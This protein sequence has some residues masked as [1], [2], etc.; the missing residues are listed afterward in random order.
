MQEYAY[1]QD[2]KRA[3]KQLNKSPTQTQMDDLRTGQAELQ[4]ETDSELSTLDQQEKL[5][6]SYFQSIIDSATP[7]GTLSAISAV[8]SHRSPQPAS[9]GAI[10]VSGA[11]NPTFVNS[12][13][14]FN[15]NVRGKSSVLH[16]KGRKGSP[17]K[18]LRERKTGKPEL[19]AW[20]IS[21]LCERISDEWQKLASILGFSELE[22]TAFQHENQ[23]NV[24][25]CSSVLDT[26]LKRQGNNEEVRQI[27]SK[28]ITNIGRGDVAGGLFERPLLR[29]KISMTWKTKMDDASAKVSKVAK[30][31]RFPFSQMDVEEKIGKI[32]QESQAN[33]YKVETGQMTFTICVES[34]D[35]LESLWHKYTTGELAKKLSETFITDEVTQEVTISESDYKQACIFFKDLESTKYEGNGQDASRKAMQPEQFGKDDFVKTTASANP[36]RQAAG[37]SDEATKASHMTADGE[38]GKRG[39]TDLPPKKQIGDPNSEGTACRG[40]PAEHVADR[41]EEELKTLYK[42]RGSYA[43]MMKWVDDKTKMVTPKLL[44]EKRGKSLLTYEDIFRWKNQDGDPCG[45]VFLTGGD[46]K[47][48]SFL[49]ENI[50]Y[51]WAAGSSPVLQKFKFV[52]A[53][54]M[55]DFHQESDFVDAIYDQLLSQRT[56]VKRT[57]LV[58][59]IDANPNKVLLIL[60]GF[61]EFLTQYPDETKCGSIIK[62]LH[63][64]AARGIQVLVSTNPSNF[65]RLLDQSLAQEPFLHLTVSGITEQDIEE[66]VRTFHPEEPAQAENLREQ[67]PIVRT[68]LWFG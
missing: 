55:V 10:N 15:F 67:I 60:H 36:P 25:R 35:G 44:S 21:R 20:C 52:A 41:C 12:T 6:P 28:A 47:D 63:Q 3:E 57:D 27:L 38:Q 8:H 17:R 48:K 37:Q 43:Q 14:H 9:V 65:R 50:T 61:D 2:R 18:Q 30:V 31:L 46:D 13:L 62:I 68:S 22:I 7:Q 49:L 39:I 16:D 54:K 59:F 58:L 45:V 23:D 51:D 29:V 64:A 33:L 66:Y 42:T 26:W 1:D 19:N 4:E 11:R 34:Q 5:S 56:D 24:R 32:L 53:L 40:D